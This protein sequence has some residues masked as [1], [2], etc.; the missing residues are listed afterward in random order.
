MPVAQKSSPDEAILII[1]IKFR[2]GRIPEIIRG[3]IICYA[4]VRNWINNYI[5]MF[6]FV[7]KWLQCN[8]SDMIESDNKNGRRAGAS[9]SPLRV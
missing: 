8:L 6:N 2:T 3:N 7:N 9:P 5:R 1:S 4:K